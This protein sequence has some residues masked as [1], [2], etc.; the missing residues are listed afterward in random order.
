[1][2]STIDPGEAVGIVAGQSI[3]EPSTQM[4]LN[5]FHLAG[6]SAK[7]VTLGIP[8]LR[9]IVM[10]ASANISTPTMTLNLHPETTEEEGQKFAKGITK[11]TLA[12]VTD[13]VTVTEMVSKGV[14]Y[15]RAKV[16]KIRIDLFPSKEYEEIYAIKVAE[17]LRTIETKFISLLERAVRK[18]LHAKGEAELSQPSSSRPEIGIAVKK[19]RPVRGKAGTGENGNEETAENAAAHDRTHANDDSEN[20]NDPDDDAT[21]FK[22]KNRGA[23]AYDA[24]D[25]EEEAIAKQARAGSVEPDED[26]DKEMDDE[27]YGGSPRTVAD[28]DDDD[29]SQKMMRSKA[30][31]RESDLLSKHRDLTRFAFDDED[32]AWCELTFEVNIVIQDKSTFADRRFST[33][34]RRPR[35]S[36]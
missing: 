9:E 28:E 17:V 7:N 22:Q 23:D 1:M 27:G 4:T 30:K 20:E 3:G 6:H 29:G 15:E 5:T 11:L 32:G 26:S 19:A 18:D 33:T 21:Q 24:P 16:Y 36:C 10:T 14:A 13:E 31:E 12:E 8:R 2:K 25:E 35:S 34:S